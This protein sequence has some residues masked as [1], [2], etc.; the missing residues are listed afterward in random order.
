MMTCGRCRIAQYCSK[1]CQKRDYSAHKEDC[2]W[3]GHFKEMM[4][5]IEKLYSSWD[6]NG[7]PGEN[8]FETQVGQFCEMNNRMFWDPP[9]SK[10]LKDIWPRD[11]MRRRCRMVEGMWE[12]ARKHESYEATEI[13]LKEILATLRLDYTDRYAVCE[14]AVFMFLYLGNIEPILFLQAFTI[15]SI[16]GLIFSGDFNKTYLTFKVSVF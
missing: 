8:L 16:S 10:L 7:R 11:Y 1:A 3:V 14:M 2:E 6:G 5:K 4:P 15:L 12:I 9:K 13:V